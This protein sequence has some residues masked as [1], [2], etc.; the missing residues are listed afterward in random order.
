MQLEVAT[1][2]GLEKIVALLGT[3][4]IRR[5]VDDFDLAIL[6]HALLHFSPVNSAHAFPQAP[7]MQLV[8]RWPLFATWS[9]HWFSLPVLPA[10][11]L[12]S[13]NTTSRILFLMSSKAHNPNKVA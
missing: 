8:W 11:L 3:E 7:D 9:A 12:L 5:L 10:Q 13:P 4:S 1:A 6:Y 2:G